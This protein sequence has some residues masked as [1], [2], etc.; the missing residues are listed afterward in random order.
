MYDQPQEG[1][2]KDMRKIR[3]QIN[4]EIQHMTFEE[5]RVYLDKLLDNSNMLMLSVPFAAEK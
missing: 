1:V 5:E 4:A 2:V 3:D